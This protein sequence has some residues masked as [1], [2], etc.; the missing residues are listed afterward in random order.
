V[1]VCICNGLREREVREAAPGARSVKEVYR[2]LGVDFQCGR[3]SC[4]AREILDDT[5]RNG[6]PAAQGP[7]TAVL[8]AVA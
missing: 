1:F 5:R 6:T 7:D 2:R 4:H 8:D 3:C